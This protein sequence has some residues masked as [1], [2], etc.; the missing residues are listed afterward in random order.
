L[1]HGIIGE[2]RVILFFCED[3]ASEVMVLIQPG[4]A[5]PM[6]LDGTQVVVLH[7]HANQFLHVVSS[8]FQLDLVTFEVAVLEHCH[9]A[10]WSLLAGVPAPMVAALFEARIAMMLNGQELILR[11]AWIAMMINS[12]KLLLPTKLCKAGCSCFD[13]VGHLV[14]DVIVASGPCRNNA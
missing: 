13:L 8:W 11:R 1:C 12:C 3:L 4:C 10:C 9:R 7:A 14:V 5:F 2:A 6:H